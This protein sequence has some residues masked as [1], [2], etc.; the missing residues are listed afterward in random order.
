MV[1]DCGISSSYSLI[2]LTPLLA[3]KSLI[4]KLVGVFSDRLRD[5]YKNH[6]QAH[7]KNL[8]ACSILLRKS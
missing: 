1:C 2:D 8:T 3:V 4:L 7:L 6:E 5:K